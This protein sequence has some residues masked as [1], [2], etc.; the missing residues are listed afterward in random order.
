MFS[1]KLLMTLLVIT[2]IIAACSP[3]SGG[4]DDKL[5]VVA[6]TT[7]I[8]DTV[9]RVAGDRVNVSVIYP[10]GTDPHAFEPRP[11]D[12]AAIADADIVFLNGLG[13]EETLEGLL[14]NAALV[15]E[16][17]DGV[18]P[19]EGGHEEEAEEEEE[20]ADEEEHEGF[21]PHV[22]QDPNNVILWANN[23]A[24]ALSEKDPANAATYQANAEA[25]VAE[26]QALDAWIAEQVQQIPE[27]RRLLVTDHETFGYFAA[28]YG[29]EMVGAIIPGGG[30]A[31][32][33]S[34]QEL[35]AIEDQI[36]QL[37]VPAVFVGNTVPENVAAQVAADTGLQLVALYTDSLTEAGGPAG[38]YLDFMR[39]NVTAIVDALK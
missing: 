6:S 36:R 32:A 21:D 20:H 26:L 15:V 1:K 23:I 29:F 7:L 13:L 34:A 3:T 17:S 33:A 2:L 25:Y 27:Q 11:Q 18:T 24:A 28:R 4:Q 9:Q 31:S 38:N 10:A 12:A 8:A 19:L 37:G 39:Y 30:T 22:W 5:K 35:A 14:G 16:V